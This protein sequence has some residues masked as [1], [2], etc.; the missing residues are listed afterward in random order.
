M[1]VLVGLSFDSTNWGLVAA[2]GVLNP[3]TQPRTLGPSFYL[4]LLQRYLPVF[5]DLD[6]VFFFS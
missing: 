4:I 2:M 1:E 5:N 3:R 6:L